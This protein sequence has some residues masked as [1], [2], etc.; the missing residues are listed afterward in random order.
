M[1]SKERRLSSMWRTRLRSRTRPCWNSS[2]RRGAT[3][4]PAEA[5]AGVK[6][7]VALS[8]VGSERNPASGYLRAKVAQENLIKGATIP[9]TIVRATQFFEFLGAIAGSGAAGQAVHLSTGMMQPIASDDVADAVADA[10]LAAPVNGTMDIAGPEKVR[11]SDIVGR[12]MTLTG[13]TRE[14]VADPHALYFGAEVDDQS[15]VPLGKARLGATRFEDWFSQSRAQPLRQIG[16]I[17]HIDA[18]TMLFSG[19]LVKVV[20]GVLFAVLWLSGRRATWF[21]WWSATFFL[22][23]LSSLAFLARD[24][25]PSFFGMAVALL[26]VSMSCCWQG[27]RT[28][29]KRLPIWIAV[30]VP[31]TLWLMA[32]AV[33][34]FLETVSSRVLLSSAL[35]APLLGRDG[36]RILARPRGAA[37]VAVDG[38]RSVFKHGADL[39]HR[40]FRSSALRRF[41]SAPFRPSRLT[42]R[43]STCSCSFTRWCSPFCWWRCRRS[44]RSL[45]SARKRRPIH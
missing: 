39:R 4:W 8:V 40:A 25:G 7:H 9:Y 32:C 33:P 1:R 13:D 14:V 16:R 37:A 6:H 12:Y 22:G 20:L 29:E 3:C 43:R 26:I 15:L 31:P 5:A 38:D 30:P 36:V 21:A 10:A 45:S 11:M 24:F 28:F 17:M 2:R 19:L 34:G 23:S 44:G 41:R 42:S 18:F 35:I 27:A